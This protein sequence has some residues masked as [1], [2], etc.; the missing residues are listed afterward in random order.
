MRLFVE[1]SNFIYIY[2][3]IDIYT[4]VCI[5]ASTQGKPPL[6]HHGNFPWTWL[7]KPS[8]SSR[9][10]N[11]H[12]IWLF[13]WLVGPNYLERAFLKIFKCPPP[14]VCQGKFCNMRAIALWGTCDFLWVTDCPAHRLGEE[15]RMRGLN[16]GM[17]ALT[18]YAFLSKHNLDIGRVNYKIRPK[19]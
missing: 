4:Y 2:I 13:V 18:A 3:Y 16:S 8:S 15:L 1:V 14:W 12:S 11:I 10:Q 9:T 17:K 19:W 5:F 6:Y 7:R